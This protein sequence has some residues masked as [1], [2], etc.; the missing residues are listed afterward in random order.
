[1][2][3]PKCS[4]KEVILRNKMKLY[5]T[6]VTKM[7]IEVGRTI[8]QSFLIRHNAAGNSFFLL[9]RC[10]KHEGSAQINEQEG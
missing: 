2:S 4:A 8:K 7:Q 3:V 10:D 6:D 1:M 5:L 9:V